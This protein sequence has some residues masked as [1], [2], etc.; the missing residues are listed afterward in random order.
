MGDVNVTDFVSV[1]PDVPEW[2]ERGMREFARSFNDAEREAF[3]LSYAQVANHE[4][5]EAFFHALP[6]YMLVRMCRLL[7]A[8]EAREHGQPASAA[9]H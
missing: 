5:E 7:Q 9:L 3:V 8:A 1:F 2:F 6:L 4:D